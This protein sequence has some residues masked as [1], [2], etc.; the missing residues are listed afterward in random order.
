MTTYAQA[1]IANPSPY[2]ERPD[3]V[4]TDENLCHDDKEKVLKSMALD[5]EQKL[6]A[7]AEGMAVDKPAYT[8]KDWL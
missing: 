3:Q 4:L 7:T 6:E 5:A 8:A 2:F 1:R